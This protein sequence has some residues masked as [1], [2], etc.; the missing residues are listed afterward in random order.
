MGNWSDVAHQAENMQTREIESW[1]LIGSTVLEDVVEEQDH[2][3]ETK[4]G[5]GYYDTSNTWNIA[6]PYRNDNKLAGQRCVMGC[7]PV[8]AALSTKRR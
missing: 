2:L 7:V 3:T 6:A 4:W 5:Q 8:A 1:V